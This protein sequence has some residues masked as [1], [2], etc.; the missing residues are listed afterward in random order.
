MS[1]SRYRSRCSH[2]HHRKVFLAGPGLRERLHNPRAHQRTGNCPSTDHCRWMRS[3]HH[4]AFLEVPA[5]RALP[6]NRSPVPRTCTRPSIGRCRW[7]HCYR[8]KAFQEEQ[9]LQRPQ[10]NQWSH[11][12]MCNRSSIDHCPYW[13]PHHHKPFR[14][15][16]CPLARPGNR[17]PVQSKR[18]PGPTG[19]SRSLD[20]RRHRVCPAMLHRRGHPGSPMEVLHKH[21]SP[22]T[23]RCQ[24]RNCHHHM[25]YRARPLHLVGPHNQ[26][27][28]Q[29]MCNQ[30][31]MYHSQWTRCRRHKANPALQ[32]RPAHR[33]NPAADR[34]RYN[35]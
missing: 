18:S 20:R 24:W 28:G 7:M 5:R 16:R 15:G 30:H 12:N 33:H 22:S 9:C 27:E 13:G 2:C 17:S 10:G 23:G 26:G 3:H 29:C 25:L 21:N 19:R 14:S 8:H 31:P 32:H 35:P 1:C 34:R 6:R 4:K 11:L